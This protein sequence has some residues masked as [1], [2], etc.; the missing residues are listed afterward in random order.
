[1]LDSIAQACLRVDFVALVDPI[2]VDI[3]SG[4]QMVNPAVMLGGADPT[5]QRPD[6]PVSF[7]IINNSQNKLL[8][9]F[10]FDF[11]TAFESTQERNLRKIIDE[12]YWLICAE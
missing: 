11:Q 6:P 5:L 8:A 7:T 1:M 3:D 10:S 9:Q 2:A 4:T 12:N